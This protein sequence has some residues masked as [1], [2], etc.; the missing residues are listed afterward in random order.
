M[1]AK[2]VISPRKAIS[3]IMV[4]PRTVRPICLSITASMIQVLAGRAAEESSAIEI[5]RNAR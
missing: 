5:Q 2:I 4:V 3:T 1:R